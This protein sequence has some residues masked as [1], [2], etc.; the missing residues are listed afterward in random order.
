[1]KIKAEADAADKKK[2]RPGRP[3]KFFF[4]IDTLVLSAFS[5][6]DMGKQVHKKKTH[7]RTNPLGNS[8]IQNGT[9]EIVPKEEEILPI[10]QK[11]SRRFMD[12][13]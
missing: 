6:S 1:L 11:V 7:K 4:F 10:I 9:A 13:R 3:L 12:S 8:T 5:I 2:S